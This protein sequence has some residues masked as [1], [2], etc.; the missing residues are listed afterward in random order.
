[1]S[2]MCYI[3]VMSLHFEVYDSADAKSPFEEWLQSLPLKDQAKLLTTIKKTEQYGLTIAA[4]Q[5]WIKHIDG[6]IW[7]IRSAFAGNIQ[8]CCYFHV[9]GT[10]Y[11]IT[12]GFTKKTRKTPQSEIDRAKRIQRQ[13][14]DE[15]RKGDA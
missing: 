8:R 7:E 15:H 11:L 6:D 1:M 5:Q 3:L 13:Y 2:R 12:H 10:H 9:K 14:L 4:R